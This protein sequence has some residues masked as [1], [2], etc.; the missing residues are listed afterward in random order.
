[1]NED[2]QAD[3]NLDS[4]K[5]E[6]ES[7]LLNTNQE[8]ISSELVEVNAE[9]E[10]QSKRKYGPIDKE[11]RIVNRIRVKEMADRNYLLYGKYRF[12]RIAKTVGVSIHTV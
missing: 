4:I 6:F 5:N 8:C 9:Q 2:K 12:C 3:S 11:K 7:I 10:V 1:M